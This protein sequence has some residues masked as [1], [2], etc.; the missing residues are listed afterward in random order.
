MNQTDKFPLIDTIL[1]VVALFLLS[2][3]QKLWMA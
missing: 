1:R 3:N 2:Y